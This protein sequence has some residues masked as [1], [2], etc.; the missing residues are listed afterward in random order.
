MGTMSRNVVTGSDGPSGDAAEPSAARLLSRLSAWTSA[1]GPAWK[2]LAAYLLYQTLAVAIWVLPILPRFTRQ[3]LGAGMSDSRYYQWA[4][5]WTPWA[6]SHRVDPLHAS[7]LFAPTGVDLAWS[8]FVPGPAFATWPVTAVFGPLASLNLLLAVAPA[9]AGWAAYLVCVRITGRYW[10]SVVG[11]CLFGFSSYMAGTMIGFANL[12]PVFPIPL[13]VY[14]VIRR[15]EGS[16]GP[17]AFVAGFAALLVALFSISTELF[18]TA[19]VFGAVA[20]AGALAAASGFRRR[21]V[22]VGVLVLTAGGLAAAVLSPYLHDVLVEP[23][24]GVRKGSADLVSFVVPARQTRLGGSAFAATMGRLAKGVSGRGLAYIG[25]AAVALLVAFAI[26][27]RRR[28]GTLPLLGFVVF[29]SVLALG[30]DLYVAGHRLA[31]LPERVL[32]RTPFIQSA[33]PARF[34][35][36]SAFVVGVIAAIWLS[37]ATGRWWW[38]RWVL[39]VAAVVSV[40]P[41]PPT[42]APPQVIPRF[43]SSATMRDQLDEGEIVFAIPVVKGDEMLWQATARFW[44]DLAEGYIGPLPPQ[45]KTGRLARGL[46]ADRKGS[47][48]PAAGQVATWMDAHR[49]SA[50]LV[51]DRALP[52][53]EAM[54]RGAGLVSVYAGEGVSIWRPLPSAFEANG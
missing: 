37:R 23:S 9:L 39:A 6:I 7:Q 26:S 49:V 33:D 34:S 36:Y 35:L 54:L 32:A 42:H 15:V 20:Y 19:T 38:A 25:I 43:L 18:G 10:P 14:L 27:E 11:G 41:M 4:L 16:L 21:L 5:T 30:P 1:L 24:A 40:L 22:H 28:R 48:V 46:Y 31:P 44:F 45:L 17:V 47:F 2:G 51:D 3:H 29:V 52:R 12:V 53:F 8:A 13:L 50:V